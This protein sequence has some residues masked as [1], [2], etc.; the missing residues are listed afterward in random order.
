M[1]RVPYVG[2]ELLAPFIDVAHFKITMIKVLLAKHKYPPDKQAE[3]TEKVIAQAE[4]LADAWS[5]GQT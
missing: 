4:L 5:E 1:L 3:A 2:R